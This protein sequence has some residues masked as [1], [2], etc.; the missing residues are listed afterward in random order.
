MSVGTPGVGGLLKN[1]MMVTRKAAMGAVRL[2][3]LKRGGSAMAELVIQQTPVLKFR[4][5]QHQLQFLRTQSYPPLQPLQHK[6]VATAFARGLKN[7]M[8]AT[9]LILTDVA[10]LAKQKPTESFAAMV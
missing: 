8:M 4:F 3:Q 7:V 6:S 1:A 9:L 5:P 2:V 10:S